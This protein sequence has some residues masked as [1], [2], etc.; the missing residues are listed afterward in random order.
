[1]NNVKLHIGQYLTDRKP[2]LSSGSL[3]R[4]GQRLERFGASFQSETEITPEHTSAWLT[5]LPV[6]NRTKR[7]YR[8][9]L[10][11]FFNWCIAKDLMTTIPI[12][13]DSAVAVLPAE[14]IPI[15][16]AEYQTMLDKATGYWE[17]AVRTGWATGLRISDVSVLE[18]DAIDLTRKSVIVT[19]LKTRRYGRIV[20]IPLSD[21]IVAYYARV[22][23]DWRTSKY[24]SPNMATGYL[25]DRR[26]ETNT[27]ATAFGKWARSLG[28]PKSFHCFRHA[29]V[30]RLLARNVQA[31]T[32]A[33]MTGQSV[34][35][36]AEY[37]HPS[38]TDKRKALGYDT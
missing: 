38:I 19:P 26:W 17:Y 11:G 20:E 12:G 16:E 33:T 28:I 21:D 3:E 6:G 7:H 15:T 22:K 35:Q 9:I 14:R 36:I 5:K 32:I 27:I 29:F 30:T 8:R 34:A 4:Y 37:Y 31:Q 1:M 23:E 18:K 2:H 13:R 24:M 25:I 10:I